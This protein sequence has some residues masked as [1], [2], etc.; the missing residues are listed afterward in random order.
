[1]KGIPDALDRLLRLGPFPEPLLGNSEVQARR[2]RR[3]YFLRLVREDLRDLERIQDLSAVELLLGRL[4]E[5]VGSP[6]SLNGLR[7]DLQVSHQTVTRWMQVLEGLYAFFRLYP[8]GAPRLRA[9]KKEAKHYHFDWGLVENE[10]LRFENLVA[11][12]LLKWCYARQDI[13]GRDTELR[14]FRD[15]DKREVDFV[16]TE[17][18]QPLL[19]CEAK[20]SD[21]APSPGLRYLKER[22][23]QVP[24]VQV[25]LKTSEDLEHR[26]GI[27]IAPAEKFLLEWA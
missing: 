17:N 25:V 3:D 4:P 24:A 20:V 11:F 14:Y 16:V 7:E 26:S 15:V 8:F 6:L 19:F 18:R 9:V 5:L 10:G 21:T 23:T 2:W 1:M 12:H 27:R 13:E 22:F